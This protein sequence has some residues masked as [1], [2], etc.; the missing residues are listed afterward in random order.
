MTIP[1]INHDIGFLCHQCV[2]NVVKGVHIGVGA[3]VFSDTFS[4]GSKTV[5]EAPH[6]RRDVRLARGI[7]TMRTIENTLFKWLE[8]IKQ[9]PSDMPNSMS[10]FWMYSLPRNSN[11]L[12]NLKGKKTLRLY[13]CPGA[14]ISPVSVSTWTLFNDQRRIIRLGKCCQMPTVH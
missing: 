2:T 1:S 14:N 9:E 10:Y 3:R 11:L 6:V 8:L 4:A 7:M 13:L 5:W 12:W